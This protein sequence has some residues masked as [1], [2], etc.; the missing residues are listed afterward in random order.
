MK[1]VLFGTGKYYENRKREINDVGQ[2]IAFIDNNPQKSN[3]F[4]DGVKIYKP[5]KLESLSY[6]YVVIMSSYMSEMKE[7][8]LALS[9]PENKI[10]FYDEII[11]TEKRGEKISYVSNQKENTKGNILILSSIM[12]YSGGPIVAMYAAQAMINRN[13]NVVIASPEIDERLLSEI[14]QRG[15]DIIV[16]KS[17]PYIFEEDF[18]IFCEYDYI[19]VNV[20]PMINCAYEISEVKPTLWW[21]HE[22]SNMYSSVY[23]NTQYLF[24][25]IDNR[26]W[27]ERKKLNIVGVSNKAKDI[28]NM[29]YPDI[30]KDVLPFGIPDCYCK[31]EKEKGDKVIIAVTANIGERKGQK[32]L[33]D[34]YCRLEKRYKKK[35]EIW[36]IGKESSSKYC[37]EIKKIA[38]EEKGIYVCGEMTRD[39]LNKKMKLIDAI[40]CP[41]LEETMSMSIVEGLMWGKIC[42]TTDQTGIAEYIEN[43]YNGFVCKAGNVDALYAIIKEIIRNKQEYDYLCKNARKTYEVNFSMDEFGY[44]LEDILKKFDEIV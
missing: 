37:Q 9:I 6:D 28:F 13:Y 15:I 14:R 36:L 27:M 38:S 30:I 35:C 43:G 3:T 2:V 34:A 22:N 32:V 17:L 20:F 41:S 26:D 24:G 10:R 39:A 31:S 8:L 4:L 16:W 25:K 7:E 11:R 40:V 33:V 19:I 21:I 29:Y 18:Q 23:S 44:K 12:D 42:V 5:D 1:L